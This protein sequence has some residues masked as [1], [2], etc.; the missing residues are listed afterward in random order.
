MKKIILS[1]ILSIFSLAYSFA[2]DVEVD[3]I[4]YNL[5]D[6]NAEVTAGNYS[7]SV[8]IPSKITVSGTDYSVTSIGNSA[9]W[10]CSGLTSVTIPN[11]VT[12]IGS[13]AF[14]NCM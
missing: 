9:F 6:G 7:G 10:G 13:D 12:S 4:C 14:Y 3:G 5:V 1:L 8:T 2:Y 11:S